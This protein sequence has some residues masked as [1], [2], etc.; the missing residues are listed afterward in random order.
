MISKNS[1]NRVILIGHVGQN[2]EIKY[3][4]SG[5]AVSTFSLATNEV[6]LSPEKKKT[7]HTEWHNIVA[8]NKLA[9]FTKEYIAKGQLIYIEGRIHSQ[10]WVDKKNIKQKR[11]E[12]VC[13]TITPLGWKKNKQQE[14]L[15]N[16]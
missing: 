15:D 9:D 4:T 13:D 7:E 16:K 6:W 2:P 14:G 10:L 5:Y 11:V 1:I 12:I 8:W 3:T